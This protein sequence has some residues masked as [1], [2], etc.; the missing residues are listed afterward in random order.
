MPGR[1]SG[2]RATSKIRRFDEVLG[3]ECPQ[4]SC[5]KYAIG[6]VRDAERKHVEPIVR[7]RSR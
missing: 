1:A 4:G 5:S 2:L 3:N 6:L 7:T